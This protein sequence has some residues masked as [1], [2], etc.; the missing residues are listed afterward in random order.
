MVKEHNMLFLYLMGEVCN[1][2]IYGTFLYYGLCKFKGDGATMD[3]EKQV[4]YEK[5]LEE[6]SRANELLP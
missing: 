2:F 3:G 4:Q 5:L 6:P 1:F